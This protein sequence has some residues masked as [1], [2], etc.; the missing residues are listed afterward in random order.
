MFK[1]NCEKIEDVSNKLAKTADDL[2]GIYYRLQKIEGEMQEIWYDGAGYNFQLSFNEHNQ[3]LSYMM[4]FVK[5]NSELL[6]RTAG[7]HDELDQDYGQA[8]SS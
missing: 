7:V 1:A 3:Q 2:K 4:N 8:M 6:K 5:N